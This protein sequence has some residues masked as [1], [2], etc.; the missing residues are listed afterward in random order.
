MPRLPSSVAAPNVRSYLIGETMEI[1]CGIGW[2][3]DE[4]RPDFL[5]TATDAEYVAEIERLQADNDHLRASGLNAHQANEILQGV[6]SDRGAR[7][8]RLW[9]ALDALVNARA[10]SGVRELVAGWNGEGRPDGPYERHPDKLG[11]TMPKTNCGAIYALDEVMQQAR[12]A[13]AV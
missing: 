10:L 7:I 3:P 9:A 12:E 13:L 4:K 6:V 1:R 2:I 8:E 11:A 5:R